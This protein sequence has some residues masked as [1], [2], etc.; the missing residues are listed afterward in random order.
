MQPR[1][2][3][4][5]DKDNLILGCDDNKIKLL[6]LIKGKVIYSYDSHNDWIL[7]IKKI[8]HPKFGECLISQGY[9]DDG[10]KIWNFKN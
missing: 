3:C 2:I 6:D 10:I 4:L 5:W 8:N 7:T 9:Q 1:E